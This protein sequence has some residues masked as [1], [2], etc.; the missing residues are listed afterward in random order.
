M[1]VIDNLYDRKGGWT[2]GFRLSICAHRS[3][4]QSAAL[5]SEKFSHD[6]CNTPC[7]IRIEGKARWLGGLSPAKH[8]FREARHCPLNMLWTSNAGTWP[9]SNWICEKTVKNSYNEIEAR[10]CPAKEIK[11]PNECDSESPL[12]SIISNEAAHILAEKVWPNIFPSLTQ[13]SIGFQD[14]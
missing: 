9:V 8:E 3:G 14:A 2:T 12:I 11:T 10:N 6:V 5:F 4:Q 13:D 1:V 7:A